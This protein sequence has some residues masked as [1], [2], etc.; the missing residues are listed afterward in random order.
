MKDILCL[1]NFNFPGFYSNIPFLKQIYSNNFDLVFYGP[2]PSPPEVIN[3]EHKDGWYSY[4]IVLD[5]VKRYP[6]YKG[7]L[8]LHDDCLL[9]V[10]NFPKDLNKVWCCNWGEISRSNPDAWFNNDCGFHAYEESLKN[11]N[12][13]YTANR[14]KDTVPKSFSDILYI[15]KDKKE[16]FCNIFSVFYSCKLFLEYAVPTSVSCLT[17]N[18][19]EL[20]ILK[21]YICSSPTDEGMIS[22]YNFDLD[23]IHPFKMSSSVIRDFILKKFKEKNVL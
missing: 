23:I 21:F 6:D 5:A 9:N 12:P 4:G 16:D 20:D 13:S 22:N 11:L 10:W 8:F 17:N 18:I 2:A 19:E 1:I 3:F 7:Y 14:K 15:P